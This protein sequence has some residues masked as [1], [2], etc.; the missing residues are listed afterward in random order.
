M[1]SNLKQ[2]IED[3]CPVINMGWAVFAVYFDDNLVVDGD[4]CFGVTCFDTQTVTVRGNISEELL[5]QTMIHES[6]HIIWST[7]GLR[8]PD[9]DPEAELRT[10]QEFLVEQTTRGIL[11]FKQL[12]PTLYK[13]LYEF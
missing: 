7:M 8:T 11:L 1:S 4:E 3:L 9:E 13:L 12:N 5:R 2:Q 6:W 10:N